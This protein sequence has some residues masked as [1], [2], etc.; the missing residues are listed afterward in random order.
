VLYVFL[1][2]NFTLLI[3]K[4]WDPCTSV[5]WNKRTET[6]FSNYR[7]PGQEDIHNMRV[8]I[9]LTS[10]TCALAY[11]SYQTKVI[12]YID[13]GTCNSITTGSLCG[14][15]GT[16]YY[17]TFT[18]NGK[19][20]V[21]I[22]GIPDHTAETDQKKANPNTRCERWQFM[23]VPINPSKATSYTATSMSSAGLAVTGGVFFNDLSDSDG[24]LALTNEGI[25]LDSCFGHSDADKQYHYHANINCTSAGSATGA[26]SVFSCTLIGYM[27]DG[28][29]LY[30]FCKN[31]SGTQ[32]TSC[33]TRNST[34]TTT[35]V[36]TAG[37]TYT[38]AYYR[39]SYY[40]DT[41][42]KTKGTCN[43][44]QANGAIH[45]TTGQ[46]S[47]FATYGYPFILLLRS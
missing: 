35:S 45:P 9:L 6:R 2:I 8:F 20:V 7:T 21:I 16:S 19:R 41:A 17:S 15:N 44:D 43:L 32:F 22:S 34:A 46:Y 38:M 27:R 39:S 26:N 1:A 42:A 36:V 13:A 40:Y 14:T 4:H 25:T 33:Y 24:S 10:F 23:S 30:G 47:Y 37:G 11:D 5:A 12:G 31:S 28:V 29:P 3:C 18:Y